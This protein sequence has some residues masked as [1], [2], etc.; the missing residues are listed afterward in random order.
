LEIRSCPDIILGM[1]NKINDQEKSSGGGAGSAGRSEG[2]AGTGGQD[3][4]GAAFGGGR[5]DYNGSWPGHA[6]VVLTVLT[7]NKRG[8]AL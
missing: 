3:D 7:V 4:A 1:A 5:I 2:R 8:M 6:G